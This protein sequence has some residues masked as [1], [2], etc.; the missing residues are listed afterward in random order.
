M[1]DNSTFSTVFDPVF[2]S[3]FG[4]HKTPII[5][6]DYRITMAGDDRDTQA[7]DDRVLQVTPK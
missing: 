6:Y 2:G 3:V 1:S 4:G 7:G 5:D